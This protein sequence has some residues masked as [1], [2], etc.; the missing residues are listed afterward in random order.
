[1]LL[2]VDINDAALNKYVL[3]HNFY[4]KMPKLGVWL[5]GRVLA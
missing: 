2:I 3:K 1:M 5:S 4:L